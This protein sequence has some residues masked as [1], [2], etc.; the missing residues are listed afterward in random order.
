MDRLSVHTDNITDGLFVSLCVA[1]IPQRV[2]SRA[3]EVVQ[4]E[5]RGESI[6]GARTAAR[7]GAE[8]EPLALES[9]MVGLAASQRALCKRAHVLYSS[10]VFKK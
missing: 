9:P 2:L 10:F 1:G 3:R 5:D 7:G 6:L 8:G 4:L